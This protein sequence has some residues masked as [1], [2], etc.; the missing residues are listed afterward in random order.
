MK[1]VDTVIIT[2]GKGDNAYTIKFITGTAETY[3]SMLVAGDSLNE[4]M[5]TIIYNRINGKWK[6]NN[7]MGEDYALNKKPAKA[8]F[9]YAKTLEKSGD[10]IDAVNVMDL[11]RHCNAPGGSIFSYNRT[12][13]MNKYS[14]SLM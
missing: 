1:P 11:A 12:T 9:S 4:I 7:I 6:V 14:D 5:L 13:A 8:Q 3:I 10:L 2:S